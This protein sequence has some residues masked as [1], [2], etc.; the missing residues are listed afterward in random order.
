[1]SRRSVRVAPRLQIAVRNCV[2][3]LLFSHELC[4][5][6][7]TFAQFAEGVQSA[8]YLTRHS[9]CA[10][11][12]NT[13][14]RLNSRDKNKG[15]AELCR[16]A[17]FFRPKAGKK[18]AQPKMAKDKQLLTN[19][20]NTL[21]SI[22]NLKAEELTRTQELG[23]ALGFEDYKAEL[24]YAISM[25]R[26]VLQSNLD[27]LSDAKV[28]RLSNAAANLANS[29]GQIRNFNP[30]G[31]NPAAEREQAIRNFRERFDESFDLLIPIL[32]N[33]AVTNFTQ[34]TSEKD[35]QAATV[36]QKMQEAHARQEQL[37]RETEGLLG[38][39]KEAAQQVGVVQHTRYF[40]EEAKSH[41]TGARIWLGITVALIAVTG[42]YAWW[43]YSQTVT[44]VNGLIAAA[45]GQ[46]NQ[47]AATPLLIQLAIAKLIAFS[48]LFSLILWS[49]RIYR[50]HRHNYVVNRHRL[51]ALST[52][53]TFAKA[54]DDPEIRNA[55]LLQ[56]TQCIFGPQATGYLPQE[57]DGDVGYPQILEIVRGVSKS[58]E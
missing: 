9:I 1:M 38:K 27:W 50:A 2:L 48:L 46:D 54:T 45:K 34:Y 24:D 55:V 44:V 51:N 7:L 6:V 52:F 15:F 49:G 20:K 17:K 14:T 23:N 28:Q 5:T 19:Y 8:G 35:A 3:F 56:A 16:N 12:S 32:A 41:T 43:N 26:E 11:I 13:R 30:R 25:H 22:A 40:S 39:A 47:V 21:L 31:N 37:V 57:K 36:L 53:E 29:L 18:D 42:A 33:A 4:D 10:R 58:R